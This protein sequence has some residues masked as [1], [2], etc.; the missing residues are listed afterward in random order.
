MVQVGWGARWG[1]ALTICWLPL[2]T[3]PRPLPPPPPTGTTLQLLGVFGHKG[4]VNLV[5]ELC[6]TDLEAELQR[7]GGVLE[8][9]KTKCIMRMLLRPRPRLCAPGASCCPAPRGVG[10]VRHY[11]DPRSE[12]A[13]HIRWQEAANQTCQ[14][15]L[16]R[17]LVR[18]QGRPV[19]LIPRDTREGGRVE[20]LLH[21]CYQV[22]QTAI[23]ASTLH[24]PQFLT[25]AMTPRALR[26]ES[27][28]NSRTSHCGSRSRRRPCGPGVPPEYHLRCSPGLQPARA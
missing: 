11:W 13:V 1:G 8:A 20:G 17:L 2:A 24:T 22:A 14:G 6:Y 10:T 9:P 23:H 28:R 4:R 5:L 16:W 12:Y 25:T 27:S 21:G 15:S 18:R 26:S 3:P 7:R 19:R